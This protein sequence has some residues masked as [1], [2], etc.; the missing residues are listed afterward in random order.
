MLVTLPLT[1]LQRQGAASTRHVAPEAQHNE[2][3]WRAEFAPALRW[4][5]ELK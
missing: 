3:A 4:L 2:A 1:V 5:F